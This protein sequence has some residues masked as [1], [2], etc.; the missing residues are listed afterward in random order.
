VYETDASSAEEC[1]SYETYD[2]GAQVCYFE[3]TTEAEC[4]ATQKSIDDEL[5]SWIDDTQSQNHIAEDATSTADKTVT[6]EYSVL[7]TE[8][9]KLVSGTAGAEDAQIWKHV[10]D[11]APDTLSDKYIESFQLFNDPSSDVLAFV[12]DADGNGK[13]RVA[14][15]I[16]GYNDSTVR[17]RN[18]TI[19][20]EL[21]HIVT[22]NNSQLHTSDTV[23]KNYETDE[24]CAQSTSFLNLFVKSF[25][26]PASVKTAL[27]K[28]TAPYVANNYV[29]EYAAT[30]PEEDMAESFAYFVL[31]A[32]DDGAL[33]KDKKTA[34]YY[35]FPELIAMRATMRQGITSDIIRSR[36]TTQ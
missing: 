36:R 34:F 18:L 11:I 10:S 15:N 33:V 29:T 28:G 5:S 9:I 26:T 23:C 30:N 21:G 3:C 22:L 25:W 1:S 17:E 12:D 31:D 6:A 2:P 7:P 24:G 14:V 19:V 27:D 32:R 13:W 16:A 4:T 35:Q 20:H 8:K